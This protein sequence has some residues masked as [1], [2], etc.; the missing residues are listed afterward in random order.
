ME[1]YIA[2]AHQMLQRK[3]SSQSLEVRETAL[4]RGPLLFRKWGLINFHGWAGANQVLISIDVINPGNGWP[5]FV[6]WFHKRLQGTKVGN[7]LGYSE[8][9]LLGKEE[10]AVMSPQPNRNKCPKV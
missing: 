9:F 4:R 7:I 6:L 1:N 5:E 3:T 10:I 8:T 2:L